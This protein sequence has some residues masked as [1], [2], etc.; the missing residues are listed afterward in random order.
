VNCMCGF[1]V[2]CVFFCKHCHRAKAQLQLNIYIYIY[3]YIVYW[4][5]SQKEKTTG[6]R[7]VYVCEQYSNVS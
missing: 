7:K 2:E 1:L 3:I 6:E 5:V 4:C